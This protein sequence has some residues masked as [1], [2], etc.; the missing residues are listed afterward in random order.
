MKNLGIVIQVV[1]MLASGIA[2]Y[3]AY[4]WMND[5]PAKSVICY[6]LAG[7]LFGL[8]ALVKRTN[9]KAEAAKRSANKSFF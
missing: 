3:Q 8:F 9:D 1:L 6:A 4:A 5:E 2:M 7:G